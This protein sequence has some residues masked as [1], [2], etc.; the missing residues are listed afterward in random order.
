MI[1]EDVNFILALFWQER[2]L[3][4]LNFLLVEIATD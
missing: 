4:F 3:L 2:A 1:I